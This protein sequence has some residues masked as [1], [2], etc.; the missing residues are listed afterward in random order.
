MRF[1]AIEKEEVFEGGVG[2][3]TIFQS[4][5]SQAEILSPFDPS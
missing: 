5:M 2:E 3:W 1:R 4:A